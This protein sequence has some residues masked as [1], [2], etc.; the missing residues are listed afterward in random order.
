MNQVWK[1]GRVAA[2][3][4]WCT[5]CGRQDRPLVLTRSGPSGLR[6]WLAGFDDEDRCLLLTCRAC[7]SWQ[8]VPLHEADDPEVVVVEDVKAE[9]AAPV[10]RLPACAATPVRLDLAP[11][12]T[13]AAAVAVSADVVAATRL[14]LTAARTSPQRTGLVRPPRPPRSTKRRGPTPRR[15]ERPLGQRAARPSSVGAGAR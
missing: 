14:V 15:P 12:P 4:G 8:V 1:V 3:D 13:A 7:G 6:A 5:P 11:D 9:R 2:W 10:R